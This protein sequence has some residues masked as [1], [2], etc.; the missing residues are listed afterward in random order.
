MKLFFLASM[1]LCNTVL[2]VDNQLTIVYQ[3]IRVQMVF[4]NAD[5]SID[6][7]VTNAAGRPFEAMQACDEFENIHGK[8]IRMITLFNPDGTV[9]LVIN[10]DDGVHVVDEDDEND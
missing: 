4:Y 1:M 9:Y 5:G 3:G 8:T 6:V 7:G 2:A 10:G